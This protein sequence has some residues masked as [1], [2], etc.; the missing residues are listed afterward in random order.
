MESKQ[1]RD[2]GTYYSSYIDL[3]YE[4]IQEQFRRKVII[5]IIDGLSPISIIEVGC[6]RNSILKFVNPIS[7][8]L[9]IEPIMEMV[10]LNRNFLIESSNTRVFNGLLCDYVQTSAE[11]YDICVLSSL[12]HEVLDQEQM[13]RDCKSVLKENGRLVLNVPNAYSLHRILAVQNG[14]LDNV[15]ELTKT[16]ISMQQDNPPF[17]IETLSKSLEL[18][19]FEI[20]IVKT[21]IPKF[22]SHGQLSE[23]LQDGSINMEFLEVLNG[24]G[25]TLEPF[26]SEIFLVARSRK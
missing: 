5:E 18:A 25:A 3:P 2:L 4:E 10:E 26:G 21:A 20:E 14:I 24:L 19:G 11:L 9:I 13:L 12:L 15:F 23:L 1:E 7:Q 8:C 16:Q 17:S 22:L 6:G